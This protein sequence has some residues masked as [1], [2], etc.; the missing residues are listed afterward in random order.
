MSEEKIPA[1]RAALMARLSSEQLR[2]RILRGEIQ[3][4]QVAGRW[5]VEPASLADY[6]RRKGTS[7]PAPA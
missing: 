5:L 3:A 2:R 1:S 7:V 4:E 6:L